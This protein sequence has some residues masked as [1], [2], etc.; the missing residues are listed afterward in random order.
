MSPLHSLLPT[1]VE[2][3]QS[4]AVSPSAVSAAPDKDGLHSVV[5]QFATPTVDRLDYNTPL[6]AVSLERYL[7]YQG[8]K[9]ELPFLCGR[10]EVSYLCGSSICVPLPGRSDDV[11]SYRHPLHMD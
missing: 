1:Q 10:G 7:S 2:V 9:S 5:Q 4:I 3:G 11:S 6:I 8:K